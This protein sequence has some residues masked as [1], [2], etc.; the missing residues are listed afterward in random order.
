VV[1][2]SPVLHPEDEESPA[3]WGFR[4]TAFE[5]LDG[6]VVKMTGDR[7]ELAGQ[8]LPDLLGWVR[9]AIHPDVGADN[10]N[11]SNYPPPIPDAR[12][13]EAFVAEVRGFLDGDQLGDDAELRLRR[14][15]GQTQE[16]MYRIK[17]DQLRRIPDLVVF[18]KTDEE[19]ASIVRAAGTHNVCL[20]PY[21]GGTNVSNALSCEENEER[22][23]VSVDMSRM[24]RILWID[25]GGC[26]WA[27]NLRT[28]RR[29]RLHNR[30]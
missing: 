27:D 22:M 21:G 2:D 16:E 5:I 14:G 29:T 12:V 8:D 11:P 13:N 1:P 25:P 17:Y 3:V 19:V 6:D 26:G 28:A 23:I 4:D 18:P 9:D 30:P 7:Y 20:I 15:H 10:L 24:N